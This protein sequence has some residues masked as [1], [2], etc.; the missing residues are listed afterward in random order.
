M[1][2]CAEYWHHRSK[3]PVHRHCTQNDRTDVAELLD[4]MLVRSRGK[5]I[6][7]LS[8]AQVPTACDTDDPYLDRGEIEQ[9]IRKLDNI[10]LL[11]PLTDHQTSVLGASYDAPASDSG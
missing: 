6:N 9:H 4:G 8:Y 11:P 1:R 3:F 5:I 10:P 2:E 7:F